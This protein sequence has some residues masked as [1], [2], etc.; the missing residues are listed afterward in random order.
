[1]NTIT[2]DEV[3]PH[4]DITRNQYDL[5]SS[6]LSSISID[7][8][9]CIDNR[10]VGELPETLERLRDFL[11]KIDGRYTEFFRRPLSILHS[12]LITRMFYNKTFE[13][14]LYKYNLQAM[15]AYAN[16]EVE[17][18]NLYA[19]YFTA[20]EAS[21]VQEAWCNILNIFLFRRINIFE[22]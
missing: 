18:R 21:L 13:S 19:I 1:M 22:F 6:E 5:L 17:Y 12:V 14:P 16:T 4:L 3:L 20:I 10:N 8:A 2:Q 7:L 9:R 11:N 15:M